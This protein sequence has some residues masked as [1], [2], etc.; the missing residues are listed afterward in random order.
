MGDEDG[1]SRD[2]KSLGLDELKTWVTQNYTNRGVA[3]QSTGQRCFKVT[4]PQELE[5]F[6][7]FTNGISDRGG[8]IDL[9]LETDAMRAIIWDAG[10]PSRYKVKVG[11]SEKVVAQNS[12]FLLVVAIILLAISSWILLRHGTSIS[13][14]S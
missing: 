10:G 1:G 13:G 8:A 7:D 14:K 2:I 12:I 6:E 5:N 9:V 4:L 11:S 3:V